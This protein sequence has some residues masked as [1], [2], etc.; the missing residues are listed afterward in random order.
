MSVF[1]FLVVDDQSPEFSV[2]LRYAGLRARA[3]KGEVVIL[4]LIQT[5]RFAHWMSI[6]EELRAEAVAEARAAASG[7]IAFLAELAGVQAEL[8]LAESDLKAAIKSVLEADPAIRAIVLAA[9]PGRG[10]PGP[11]VSSLGKGG[12]GGRPVAVVVIPGDL[13]PEAVDELAGLTG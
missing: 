2:A 10:G 8:A 13:S 6:S 11:L 12:L 3:I 1:K 4:S 7:H 5:S 9:A